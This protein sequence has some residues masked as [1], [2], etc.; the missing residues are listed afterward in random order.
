MDYL[1]YFDFS[2]EPFSNAPLTRFF[3]YA[4]RQHSEALE[5]LKYAA[6]SM[7]GLAILIGDIGLGKT[8]LARRMLE[9]LP[10]EDYEAAMLVVVHGGIT[11]N[12]LLKRIAS[13][14]HQ[15]EH[16]LGRDIPG[17]TLLGLSDDPSGIGLHELNP[18]GNV[19]NRRD[20]V[21][22]CRESRF[23]FL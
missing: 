13:Q 14:L 4:S 1:S 8:T 9:A 23:H 3:Y 17:Q 18:P 12:W 20:P 21:V 19:E 6:S 10:E 11:P 15:T 22:P 7:K 16:L 5:R 2:S